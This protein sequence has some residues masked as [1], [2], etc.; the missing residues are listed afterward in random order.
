MSDSV[1]DIAISPNDFGSSA[2]TGALTRSLG[3]LSTSGFISEDAE[4]WAIEPYLPV[5]PHDCLQYLLSREELRRTMA[6]DSVPLAIPEAMSDAAKQLVKADRKIE[7]IVCQ[8]SSM[9]Q[10]R[11]AKLYRSMDP[12]QE[13]KSI[14]P[15]STREPHDESCDLAEVGNAEVELTEEDRQKAS[16]IDTTIQHCEH[17]L[18]RAGYAKLDQEQI[19]RCAGIASQWGVPLHVDFA[20]FERL[21]VHARGDVVGTRVCRRLRK[22]YRRENVEVPIYQR[23]IILFQLRDDQDSD[24]SLRS[25]DLHLRMFKNIPQQDIDMLLPGTRVRISGVDRVKI[26]LPSLGGF[27]MS[28]RKIA[29]YALLFAVLTLNWIAILVALVVGYAIKSFFSYFQTK[30]RY[31]LHLTR[32]LYFQKLDSNAGVAYHLASQAAAQQHNEMLVA[33]F[34]VL[35][36]DDAISTRRL[37]RRCERIFRE[38]VDLEVDFQVARAVTTLELSGL[39]KQTENGWVAN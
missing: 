27:L 16:S 12:D 13:C 2:G 31:Q 22:F 34:A 33:Y 3:E 21:V 1:A 25:T 9:D 4:H 18:E 29:S 26:I 5:E 28:V 35:T 36:H 17:M 39:V 14:A 32:N 23:M 10:S 38:A 30:N 19:E 11:F 15:T 24:E 37:R 7:H 8:R 6:A 20:L